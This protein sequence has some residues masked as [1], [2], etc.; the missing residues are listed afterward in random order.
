MINETDVFNSFTDEELGWVIKL[1]KAQAVVE[2]HKSEV[3][4]ACVDA[5]KWPSLGASEKVNKLTKRLWQEEDAQARLTTDALN[6]FTHFQLGVLQSIHLPTFIDEHLYVQ[7]KQGEQVYSV[8]LWIE[9]GEKALVSASDPDDAYSRALIKTRVNPN[10]ILD[11]II[12]VVN[13][14]GK[15]NG[16][17]NFSKK[18]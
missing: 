17:Q 5:A 9:K 12:E 7:P 14:P 16:I 18:V 15:D 13:P 8:E 1:A 10:A 4:Q 6:V 3:E 11:Q 2:K